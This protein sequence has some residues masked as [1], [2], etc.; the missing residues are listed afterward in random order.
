MLVLFEK[1][2]DGEGWQNVNAINQSPTENIDADV[3]SISNEK[4]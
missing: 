1:G 2:L 3:S 4:H